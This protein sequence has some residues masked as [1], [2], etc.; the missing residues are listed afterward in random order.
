VGRLIV[1][2]ITAEDFLSY[3]E[4]QQVVLN[5]GGPVAIVGDNGAGKS[6]L[7]S[8]A[9]AWC[10]YGVC[11]PERMGSS[12]RALR[13]KDVV[14]K[15]LEPEHAATAK[16]T[17]A[18][19]A[20]WLRDTEDQ[21]RWQITRTRKRT[22][23]DTLRIRCVNEA[24]GHDAQEEP[25]Q[26]FI[27]R[28]IGADYDVFVRTCLR[29]QNDP[30]NF[31]EA[32]D[33]K[34]RE[35]LDSISG[36]LM[37]NEPLK[38]AKTERDQARQDAR[39]YA[40]RAEDA[41]RRAS[42]IDVERIQRQAAE[43]AEGRE[44]RL[45]GAR[46]EVAV[47]EAARDAAREHD[48]RLAEAEAERQR[49]AKERPALDLGP[50]DSA[51]ADARTAWAEAKALLDTAVKAKEHAE[52][53][54]AQGACPECGQAIA[55][56]SMAHT[57]AR[58][59]PDADAWVKAQAHLDACLEA[60]KA[61]LAWLDGEASAWQAQIDSLPT[62]GQ[63]LPMAEH[64]VTAAERRLADIEASENPYTVAAAEAASQHFQLVREGAV[65]REAHAD[66]QRR[67]RLA[68]AWVEVL[69]PK[70]VRAHMAESALA[71]IE[72]EANRW[73]AV[74][75]DGL[76]SVAFPATKEV[77]RTKAVKE[78]IQTVIRKG[79]TEL[80][81]LAF[82]GGERRRINLAVDLGVAATFARGGALALSLLVLDEEVFS[83]L[84]EGGKAGVVAALHHA[85]VADVVVIDHD[86]RL[87]GVLPRTVEVSRGPDGYSRMQEVT[88]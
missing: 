15:R 49:L 66:A 7:V 10:L 11:S 42:Q 56:G 81:F 1:E 6:T 65:L 14:R 50:Y 20:L 17:E 59:E 54:L 73:L 47:A 84:D 75:T 70:G 51:I 25:T 74:L 30:W 53:L 76:C 68:D 24:A 40:V 72:A 12:T 85:G 29:G 52:H 86:P 48:Q 39:T 2:S 22:G 80:P 35:I 55:E 4:P 5:G 34:K 36:A 87:S 77:K 43:W 9:L 28:L 78:E 18:C 82:S 57:A 23:S 69:S 16:A 19:V 37:L 88:V 45:A 63:R 21:T 58:S 46:D 79:D 33:A 60:K 38:R 31:A 62:G 3:R 27:D 26:A 71:A 8:K 61:A 64:A 32:T 44:A 83:G 13:G 67:E 41:E